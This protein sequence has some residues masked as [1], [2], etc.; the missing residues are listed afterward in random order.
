ME[1]AAVFGR[2]TMEKCAKLHSAYFH[3]TELSV[4]SNILHVADRTFATNVPSVDHDE[5]SWGDLVQ[6][7]NPYIY[8]TSSSQ[9][10]NLGSAESSS[11]FSS[12]P[13]PTNNRRVNPLPHRAISKSRSRSRSQ[14]KPSS[15]THSTRQ[16]PSIPPSSQLKPEEFSSQADHVRL[17]NRHN[18]LIDQAMDLLQKCLHWDSTRRITARDALLH[19]FLLEDGNRENEAIGEGSQK[20]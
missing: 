9:R 11:Q 1:L 3:C 14:L 10:T 8:Q 7:I 19:P 5:M 4:L 6:R 20:S 15:Q 13:T 12:F 18:E 17:D 2:Q 16:S